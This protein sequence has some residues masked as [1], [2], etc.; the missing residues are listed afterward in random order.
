MFAMTFLTI[1]VALFA[2]IAT[3]ELTRWTWFSL[4]MCLNVGFFAMLLKVKGKSFK[5]KP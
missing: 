2:D 4:G 1:L 3:S 5:G